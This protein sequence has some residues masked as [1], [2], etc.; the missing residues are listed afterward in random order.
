VPRTNQVVASPVMIEIMLFHS[1]AA[2]G[3]CFPNHRR[4][5]VHNSHKKLVEA[6]LL[7]QP[8]SEARCYE[9]TLRGRLYVRRL[10]QVRFIGED[11][12]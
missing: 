4:S 11:N 1:Y 6:G 10:M 9:I 7:R 5:S 12:E 2:V 8:S 3:E